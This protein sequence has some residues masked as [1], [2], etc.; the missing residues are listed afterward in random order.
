V[1]SVVLSKV[2]KREKIRKT[3]RKRHP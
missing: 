3:V 1:L 2:L